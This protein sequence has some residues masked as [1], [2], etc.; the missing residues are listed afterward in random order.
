MSNTNKRE[1]KKN[2]IYTYYANILILLDKIINNRKL[3]QLCKWFSNV[4]LINA[5][6]DQ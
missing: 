2:E 1:Q 4:F 5:L 3:L 6:I